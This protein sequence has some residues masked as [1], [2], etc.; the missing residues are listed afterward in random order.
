LEEVDGILVPGGD[1][2]N[3]KSLLKVSDK[4]LLNIKF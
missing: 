2:I 1:L 3:T 4:K